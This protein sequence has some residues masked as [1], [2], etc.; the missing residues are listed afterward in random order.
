LPSLWQAL[1]ET[2]HEI[3]FVD[4]GGVRTRILLAGRG[5]P[6]M[7]LHG[8]GGHLESFIHNVAALAR[9]Y[10]VVAMDLVGHGYTQ[11]PT[12]EF[13]W[14][15]VAEHVLQTMDALDL[16]AAT[17]IGEALGAQAAE[18]AAARLPNRVTRLVLC[19]AGVLPAEDPADT[20]LTQAQAAFQDLTRRALA[21]PHSTE[22]M[23]ERMA[24]L[25]LDPAAVDDE[26]LGMRVNFWSQPGFVDA[27]RRLLA[28]L[29]SS[30]TDP[31]TA[32][33]RA[34]IEGIAMPTLIVWTTHN[35]LMGIDAARRLASL[36]P[37]ARVEVFSSSAMWPQFDEHEKFN[38]KLIAWL[39]ASP[40]TALTAYPTGATN[41][42]A[43]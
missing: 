6:V 23:R 36:M 15:T 4:A 29:P 27:Q 11:A 8:T 5:E 35:P 7:L 26:M 43:S 3:R 28:S 22:L 24:W 12:S 37:N 19:C 9:E 34:D 31:R 20:S 17:W 1:A 42:A 38:S 25:H 39:K 40:P 41:E 33:S 14:R 30:R 32:L 2:P 10:R 21:D 16:P 18:W 13:D